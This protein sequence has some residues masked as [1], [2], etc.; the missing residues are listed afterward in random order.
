MDTNF[1]V[2]AL[3]VGTMRG[4]RRHPNLTISIIPHISS[5]DDRCCD[6]MRK[7]QL[8]THLAALGVIPRTKTRSILNISSAGTDD[9]LVAMMNRIVRNEETSD[10]KEARLKQQHTNFLEA[11]KSVSE[12]RNIGNSFFIRK[13]S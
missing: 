13:W 1:K 3:R 6:S 9:E 8:A 12:E 2:Y 11:C 5:I 7:C 10:E 4:F